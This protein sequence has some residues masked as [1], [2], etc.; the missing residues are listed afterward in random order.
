LNTLHRLC[1][2]PAIA[3]LILIPLAAGTHTVRAEPA[4]IRAFSE[5][6]ADRHGW[7]ARRVE[8]LLSDEAVRQPDIIEAIRQPAEALPWSRYRPIFLTEARI[9]AGRAFKERHRRWLTA[10][11]ERY[12]VPADI[13]TAI[14]GV[15]TF[16]GRYTGRY[17]VIDALRTLGFGYPPRAAFFRD[18]LEAFLILAREEGFDPTDPTGSY[19]GAMGIPQFISSSYRAYAVDFND[20]GRRDLFS[21]PADAIGSIGHYL[22]RHGWQADAPIAIPARVEGQQWQTYLRDPLAPQDTVGTLVAAGV[23][24]SAPLSAELEARLLQLQAEAG[25]AYWI[26]LRNFYAITRYNHSALYAMAVHQLA[27]R[28][29]GDRS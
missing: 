2:T 17:R 24:P 14:I 6:L 1:C 12:G 13:V 16:Y 3:L 29:G 21:E 19:A 7:E 27:E 26:T 8:A 10:V 20:N 22:A 9:D 4:A 18:E 28:I 5:T 11:Q 25:E 15:E 23:H